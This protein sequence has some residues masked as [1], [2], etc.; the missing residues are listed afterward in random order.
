MTH[1]ASDITS[2]REHPVHPVHPVQGSTPWWLL[3]PLDELEDQ[4]V[5]GQPDDPK[6]WS[7]SDPVEDVDPTHGVAYQLDK[8][9]I[10]EAEDVGRCSD[11]NGPL[12]ETRTFDGYLNLECLACDQCFGCRRADA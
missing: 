10:N 9:P 3:D 1:D 7:G 2:N 4:P 11:C 6:P 12:V 8:Q 5:P